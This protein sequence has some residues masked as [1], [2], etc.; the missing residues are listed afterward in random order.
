MFT[1]AISFLIFAA[2]S[3]TL[4]SGLIEGEVVTLFG[5]DLYVD[6]I[7]AYDGAFLNETVL[8]EFLEAQ[9]AFDGAISSYGYISV[10]MSDLTTLVTKDSYY[11]ASE[12]SQRLGDLTGYNL[13]NINV[14][15]VPEE[16]LDIV[17]DNYYFPN[18]FQK[19]LDYNK[20]NG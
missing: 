11:D 13:I 20:T 1:L 17:D 7:Q 6:A 14:M 19:G 5:S 3:F 10:Q 4:L 15:S 9:I 8:S 12:K 2:S 16:Y 18:T